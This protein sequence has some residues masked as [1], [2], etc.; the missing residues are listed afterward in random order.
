MITKEDIKWLYL[1]QELQFQQ[2]L[3]YSKNWANI[4]NKADAEL[5][6]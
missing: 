3:K 5:I 4:I 1:F 2:N 6:A